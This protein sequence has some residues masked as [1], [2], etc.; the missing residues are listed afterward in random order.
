MT[1]FPNVWQSS[2][3]YLNLTLITVALF[4]VSYFVIDHGFSI[5]SRTKHFN[6]FLVTALLTII[7]TLFLSAAMGSIGPYVIRA[8]TESTYIAF[9]ISAILLISYGSNSSRSSLWVFWGSIVAGLSIWIRPSGVVLGVAF[10]LTAIAFYGN[11]SRKKGAA[12]FLPFLVLVL[13][14]SAYN[15]VIS[16]QFTY[17]GFGAQNLLRGTIMLIENDDSYPPLLQ[18]GIDNFN[19]TSGVEQDRQFMLDSWNLAVIAKNEREYS[20]PRFLKLVFGEWLEDERVSGKE[21]RL[22]F[23][24]E[25]QRKMAKKNLANNPYAYFKVS[26]GRFYYYFLDPGFVLYSVF[27]ERSGFPNM[28]L[29]QLT[30]ENIISYRTSK[31][32]DKYPFADLEALRS[33]PRLFNSV[34]EHVLQAEENPLVMI[35]V[36]NNGYVGKLNETWFWDVPTKFVGFLFFLL[37]PLAHWVMLGTGIVALVT[38]ACARKIRDEWFPPL[39][40]ALCGCGLKGLLVLVANWNDRYLASDILLPITTTL[41]IL[42][43]LLAR[44]MKAD[45]VG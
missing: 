1:D 36:S 34:R 37:V 43:I 22:K 29:D 33:D 31:A 18:K 19:K 16:G 15:Y 12:V 23:T 27:G 2:V 9:L 44:F 21:K 17:S 32:F 7:T 28:G 11:G 6:R 45:R 40:I 35:S 38:F 10:L 20:N 26:L 30:Y 3:V 5:F 4:S 39:F 41:L 13:C 25:Y 8:T 42:H 14:L 24:A